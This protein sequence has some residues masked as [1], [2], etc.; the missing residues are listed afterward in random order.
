[1]PSVYRC[2]ART[3]R[4]CLLLLNEP[5]PLN[6]KQLIETNRPGAETR[7]MRVRAARA[8]ANSAAAR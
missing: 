2:D 6:T 8:V 1:M 4:V 3:R 7:E 5:V